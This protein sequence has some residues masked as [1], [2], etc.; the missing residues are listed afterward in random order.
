[1][2]RGFTLIEVVMALLVLE[3]AVIGVL[4]S[5]MVASRTAGRAEQL[6]RLVQYVEST[7]DSLRGGAHVG[8]DSVSHPEGRI[9]WS[10]EADGTLTLIAVGAE[11]VAVEV[12][13]RVPP[14]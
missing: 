12:S 4:G 2:R 10:V 14:R 6:E 7:L 13:S 9:A 11:G 8:D 3:V 1:M 5:L